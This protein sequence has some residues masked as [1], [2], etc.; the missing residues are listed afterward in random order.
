MNDD[1]ERMIYGRREQST[2][3][4]SNRTMDS[5]IRPFSLQAV[6]ITDEFWTPRLETNRLVTLEH[7]YEHIKANGCLDNF[8]RVLGE[9]GGGFEGPT[10]IDANA[11]KW[12]EAASYSLATHELPTLSEKMEEII[13]LIERAQDSDGYLFTYLMI[14]DPDKRWTNFS[15]M[16]ELYCAGH[17]IEAATAHY[18]AIGSTRLL[19]VACALANHL[20]D[21]F[22]PNGEEKIPGH[23]EIE[24]ALLELYEVTEERQY[25]QLAELF[26]ERRGRDPSPLTAELMGPS[27]FNRASDNLEATRDNFITESGNYDGRYAQDHCPIRQH[28]SVEGHAVRAMNF[29]TAAATLLRDVDD[30]GLFDALERVWENMVMKRMYVTGGIGSEPGSESFTEDYDLPNDAAFAEACA[31][32]GCIF[33]GQR[34]FELTGHGRYM[35]VIERTLYN[36]LL[37]SISLNG[38]QFF[39]SNPLYTDGNHHRKEWLYVACCPPNVSRVLASLER[40]V[41]AKSDAN[42]VLFV[43]LYIGSE[44][45]AKVAGTSLTL[46]QETDYPW[47]GTATFTVS[48]DDPTDFTINFRSPPWTNELEVRVNGK[49]VDSESS[50]GY[51][52]VERTWEDDDRIHFTFP[53]S[54]EVVAAH[55]EVHADAGRVALRRGPLVYC[56]ESVDNAYPVHRIIFDDPQNLT[57]RYD[58]TLLGGVTVIDGEGFVQETEQWHDELYQPLTEINTI[59][60]EFTAVPYYVWNNRGKGSM[61]VW[62]RNG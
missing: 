6:K 28:E 3:E 41:Y 21:E 51:T 58:E 37:A 50:S 42:D 47:D 14:K 39:Y 53:M 9:A 2:N 46:I 24:L 48:L 52:A 8:R 23:Q 7:Q 60:T 16:H 18:R 32:A 15:M 45:N 33:W 38:T 43:N 10:F 22:G 55:P 57:V 31:G 34:M 5:D 59:A 13:T 11:Y 19:D 36:T 61:T 49:P 4:V 30:L 56:L 27:E 1:A 26:I 25:F 20:Y 17:L 40:H 29:Y 62:M 44:L 35:N 54:V 12:L